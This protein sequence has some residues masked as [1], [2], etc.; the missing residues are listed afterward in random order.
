MSEEVM[1]QFAMGVLIG[2][3]IIF[4]LLVVYISGSGDE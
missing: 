2:L 3:I 1:T 4:S